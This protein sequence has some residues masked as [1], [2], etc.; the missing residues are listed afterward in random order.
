VEESKE[1]KGVRPQL[2]AGQSLALSVSYS[3]LQR[4]DVLLS[5]ANLL[6]LNFCKRDPVPIVDFL[7][8]KG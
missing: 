1:N 2:G 3:N 6:P 7:G 5:C 4:E 8:H